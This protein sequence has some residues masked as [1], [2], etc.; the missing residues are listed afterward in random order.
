MAARASLG[1]P[2]LV[3]ALAALAVA[4]LGG[5]MT[6]TGPWYQALEE[7]S[8]QPPGWLFA[9]A[10]TLIFALTAISGVLAWR[11]SRTPGQRRWIIHLFALNGALNILWSALFFG[12][13]RPDWALVEVA[14]LWLSILVLMIFLSR[15]SR[16]AAALL[17]PYLAWVAFAAF[18]N[19]TI[20]QLNPRFGAG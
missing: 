3:A 11:D 13:H 16:A 10:W 1:R 9:P 17:F 6:D 7:P 20:V 15:F 4:F 19:F 2:T 8:W 18:L 12:L 14:F 5:L